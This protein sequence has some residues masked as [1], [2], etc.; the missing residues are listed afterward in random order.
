VSKN[1]ETRSSIYACRVS[2]V[3]THALQLWVSWSRREW[4]HTILGRIWM[5]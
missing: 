2:F 4:S 5:L 3:F 1:A